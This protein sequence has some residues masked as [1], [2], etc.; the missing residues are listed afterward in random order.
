MLSN[1]RILTVYFATL[2]R[3][4]KYTSIL[5]WQ[6]FGA[7]SIFYP[8]ITQSHGKI[9]RVIPDNR[10]QGGSGFVFVIAFVVVFDI[11]LVVDVVAV[12]VVVTFCCSSV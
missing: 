3:L 10:V 11:L 4:L 2:A 7:P 1:K 8:H 12:V 5:Y 9:I 6:Y